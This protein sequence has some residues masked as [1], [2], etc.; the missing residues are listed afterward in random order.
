MTEFA[1]DFGDGT[2]RWIAKL[3]PASNGDPKLC[4]LV[5]YKDGEEIERFP[6]LVPPGNE[7]LH[8][9][10]LECLYDTSLI[11]EEP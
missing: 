5:A 9:Y 6:N 2:G 4:D 11:K 3:K 7:H 8:P 10:S 1:M